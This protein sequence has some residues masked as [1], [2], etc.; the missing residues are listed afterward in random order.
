MKTRAQIYS[1]EATG[2]LY[3]ISNYRVLKEEQ[4]LRL[5]PDKRSK[6]KN[7]LDY[8]TK[9]GRIF[10]VGDLYCANPECADNIDQGLLSAVWVL[11]DFSDRMEYHAI[12][13]FPVKII[14]SADGEVYEIVHAESGR[15]ALL[16]Y[17]MGQERKEPPHYIVL[18]DDVEQIAELDLPNVNGYCTVSP[19]GTV[20]YYQ[21]S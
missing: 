21:K 5:Y 6:V 1:H 14:F 15:E 7:L 20:Q 18:V 10:R 16:T 19:D 4:L 17:V 9:Q 8:L 2:L 12:G 3:D 11:A 13:D